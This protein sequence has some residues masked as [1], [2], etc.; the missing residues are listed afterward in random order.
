MFTV[1]VILV[2][3]AM[4]TCFYGVNYHQSRLEDLSN[5][6]S[7]VT[8]N[9]RK[10]QQRDRHSKWAFGELRKDIKY[11]AKNEGVSFDCCSVK[12][13]IKAIALLV[14]T[15]RRNRKNRNDFECLQCHYKEMA[16][17]VAAL[18]IRDRVPVNEPIIAPLFSVVTSPHV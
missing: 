4:T 7:R 10:G 8:V 1:T 6:R 5:I 15:D 9:I 17:Y 18:N 2:F 16:D 12:E 3:A 14:D 13:H 11:K